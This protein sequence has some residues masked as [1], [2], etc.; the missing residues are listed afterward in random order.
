MAYE[1]YFKE[2][3]PNA[4]HID[5]YRVLERFGV[6]DPCVQHAVK[7]L[8]LPGGRGVKTEKQDIQEAIDALERYKL[9]REEEKRPNL[10]PIK[11]KKFIA[12]AR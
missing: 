5:V 9:M 7:K 4:T 10:I 11:S 3:P 1:H 6:K 8:L 12:K 2:I